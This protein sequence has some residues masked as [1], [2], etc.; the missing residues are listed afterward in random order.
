MRFL[1]ILA[2]IFV[3]LSCSEDSYSP[4]YVKVKIGALLPK[5]GAGSSFGESAEAALNIAKEEAIA[6]LKESS[7]NCDIEL[8]ILDTETD[9]ATAL[10]KAIELKNMGVRYIIG[11]YSSASA[12]AIKEFV[13]ND[14]ILVVSPFSVATSLAEAGDNIFRFAPS[15]HIQADAICAMMEAERINAVYSIVRDDL[16]GNNLISTVYNKYTSQ[17]SNFLQFNEY[18]SDTEDFAQI[19]NGANEYVKS[20]VAQRGDSSVAVYLISFGEGVEIL[21]AAAE[22]EY[23]SQ[24][25]WY[26]ASAFALNKDILNN[27]NAAEFAIS[28]ELSCPLFG[29]DEDY[30][31]NWESLIERIEAEIG[32]QPEVYALGAYDALK[33]GA[34]TLARSK[35]LDFATFREK[36]LEIANGYVGAIGETK[37]N[38]AGDIA[39]ANFDFWSLAKSGA[40]YEWTV[41][42]AFD[43]ETKEIT[44]HP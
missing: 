2:L 20:A 37:L 40:N 16:W 36:F 10:Q 13:D 44:Y 30:R 23:L 18:Q 19:L 26:G 9:T 34:K 1:I 6:E 29:L 43:S 41:V 15:D 12:A 39:N 8:I 22:Y 27:E 4:S 14:E 3:L 25:K 38:P 7:V 33:V 32:R 31:S 35:G 42:A 17:G 21:E 28:T 11:P 5:T 24:V